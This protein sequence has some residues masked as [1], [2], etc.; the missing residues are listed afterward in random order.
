YGAEA[1]ALAATHRV[2]GGAVVVRLEQRQKESW[3]V[4]LRVAVE[5]SR[6]RAARV[7]VLRERR[8]EF[9]FP[10]PGELRAVR[11][12][13]GGHLPVRVEHE[14]PV[15]MLLHQLAREPDLAGRLDALDQ[16]QAACADK[17]REAECRPL[18]AALAERAAKDA[19]RLVRERA[20]K[21]LQPNTTTND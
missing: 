13:D 7:V 11:L 17:S 9:R 18:R 19:S 12:V 3:P 4:R 6:G 8:Q 21:A 1:P 10:A 14:R 2:E 15:S 16:L 20:A 5:T